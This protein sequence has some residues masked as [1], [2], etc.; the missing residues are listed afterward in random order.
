MNVVK[1]TCTDHTYIKLLQYSG[2]R[3]PPGNQTAH[4]FTHGDSGIRQMGEQFG[5]GNSHCIGL[6]EESS[7]YPCSLTTEKIMSTAKCEI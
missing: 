6:Q 7:T 1:V 4:T 5:A 2:T 3:Y